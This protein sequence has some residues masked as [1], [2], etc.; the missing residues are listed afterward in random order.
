MMRV[1]GEIDKDRNGYV[2]NAELDDILKMIFP[3]TLGNKN[4]RGI[5]AHF[6][7]SANKVLI[8]YKRF[9]D[10]IM[11]SIGITKDGF[12]KAHEHCKSDKLLMAMAF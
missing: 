2:T 6:S 9:R 3:T 12:S 7:S 4:I 11:E 1:I 8:D 10:F 5:F